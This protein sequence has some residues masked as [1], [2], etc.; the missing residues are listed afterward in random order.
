MG[1]PLIFKRSEKK[2]ILN[3]QQGFSW[4]NDLGFQWLQMG[5]INILVHH[6]ELLKA[7]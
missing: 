2:I 5:L 6:Y 4:T 1:N 3:I 7:L